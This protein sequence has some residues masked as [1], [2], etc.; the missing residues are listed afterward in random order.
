MEKFFSNGDED[1]FFQLFCFPGGS[2]QKKLQTVNFDVTW[3]EIRRPVKSRRVR[4]FKLIVC[5]IRD[6]DVIRVCELWLDL[7]NQKLHGELPEPQ[8][9]DV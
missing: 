8:Y 4:F 1:N 3:P 6:P 5:D 2:I 9:F 7:G